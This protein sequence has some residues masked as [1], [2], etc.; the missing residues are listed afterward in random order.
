LVRD[1]FDSGV[2]SS[3]TDWSYK[4]RWE[5]G[6]DWTRNLIDHPDRGHPYGGWG[7]PELK[8]PVG[9]TPWVMDGWTVVE[10]YVKQ[11]PP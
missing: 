9:H 7:W 6:G 8:K 2:T 5:T 1:R 11:D 10:I 4:G 3:A